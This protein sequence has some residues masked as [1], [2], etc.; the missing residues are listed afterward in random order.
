MKTQIGQVQVIE[1]DRSR[2]AEK[3]KATYCLL[4]CSNCGSETKCKKHRLEA[5]LKAK[6]KTCKQ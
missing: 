6:C 3:K 4:Q 1:S 5:A 2:S